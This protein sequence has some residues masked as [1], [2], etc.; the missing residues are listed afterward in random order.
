MSVGRRKAGKRPIACTNHT[1]TYEPE[2]TQCRALLLV[3][4]TME[5]VDE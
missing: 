1:P 2:C 5:G 4:A 3:I